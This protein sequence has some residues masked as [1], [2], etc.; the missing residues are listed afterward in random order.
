M[1]KVL[2][3]GGTGFIGMI[4]SRTFLDAGWSVHVLDR[5][6]P[7]L[8]SKLHSHNK[9]SFQK[10]DICIVEDVERA[11]LGCDAV[12]HLAAQVSIPKSFEHPNEN[13]RTNVIGTQNILDASH[14]YG[15]SSFQHQVLPY[16]ERLKNYL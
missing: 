9:F 3:T 7:D 12:V 8:N 14:K 1:A 13:Y 5:R 10:G 16:T 4:C 6:S 11:I 15:V 2:L